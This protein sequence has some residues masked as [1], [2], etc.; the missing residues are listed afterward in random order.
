MGGSWGRRGKT[1]SIY[2]LTKHTPPSTKL[3]TRPACQWLVL[4]SR[5]L[6]GTPN[7]GSGTCPE[8]RSLHVSLPSLPVGQG[9]IPGPVECAATSCF[10]QL[11]SV[12][13]HRWHCTRVNKICCAHNL[14]CTHQT[15]PFHT[16]T[17][18][19]TQRLS[20]F[21]WLLHGT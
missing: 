2:S 5:H 10:L 11:I 8:C 9:G 20:L 16:Q 12:V 1:Q 3:A 6:Q 21:Q 13:T 4:Q 15:V 7:K 19:T 18:L 14:W 17:L